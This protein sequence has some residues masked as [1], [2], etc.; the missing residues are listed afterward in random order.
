[1]LFELL[2]VWRASDDMQRTASRMLYLGT[3]AAVVAALTGLVAEKSVPPGIA[4]RVVGIHQAL[5]L[6]SMSLAAALCIFAFSVRRKK[7]RR[8]WLKDAELEI[9]TATPSKSIRGKWDGGSSRLS[10][11]FYAKGAEKC[12]VAVDHMKLSS[13]EECAKMKAYWFEALNRLEVLL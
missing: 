7:L 11:N 4:Q 10:V 13:S 12:Q 2:A 8:G 1:L 5:M 3:L 9:T 6:V